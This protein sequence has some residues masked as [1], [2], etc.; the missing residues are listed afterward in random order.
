MKLTEDRRGLTL[1]SVCEAVLAHGRALTDLLPLQ[2]AD[3]TFRRSLF[4]LISSSDDGRSE[5]NDREPEQI[6]FLREDMFAHFV[7]RYFL[8]RLLIAVGSFSFHSRGSMFDHGC[9]TG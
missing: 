8:D 2:R 4:G 5:E 9:D 6:A 1:Q 3:H 7:R